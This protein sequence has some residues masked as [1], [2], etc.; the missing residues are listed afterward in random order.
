MI[1]YKFRKKKDEYYNDKDCSFDGK[2]TKKKRSLV[3]LV[4]T[5]GF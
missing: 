2:K 1:S 5:T 4:R 3:N